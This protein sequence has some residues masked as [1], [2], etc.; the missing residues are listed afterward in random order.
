MMWSTPYNDDGVVLVKP[1]NVTEPY[2]N[3]QAM[4]N[5]TPT[6]GP[7][8]LNYTVGLMPQW[9][10]LEMED[11]RTPS[12]KRMVSFNGKPIVFAQ[13]FNTV[14]VK[15][16]WQFELGGTIQTPGYSQNVM[17]TSPYIDITAAIQKTL[18]KDGSLVLRLEGADL[19]Y[20]AHYNVDTDF[21]S[22]TIT[23]TNNMDTQKVKFSIRYSFNTAQSKYKGTGAGADQKARM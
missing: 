20:R 1:R 11:P 7:W 4:V 16:G 19:I 22:H 2:R 6:V 3:L 15:G 23:Q 17:L 21:G 10:S 18:L 5:I 9:F 8:T 13:L 14:T 12:G